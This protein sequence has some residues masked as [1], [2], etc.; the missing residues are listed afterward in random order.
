MSKLP[1]PGLLSRFGQDFPSS[2]LHM[3]HWSWAPSR[4]S[5]TDA[6][7]GQARLVASQTKCA[8]R[9]VT[10]KGFPII[11]NLYA[12]TNCS[13]L[14]AV[15]VLCSSNSIGPDLPDVNYSS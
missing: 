4:L 13:G 11:C 2:K 15:W 8:T 5:D 1:V 14:M 3:K 7:T 10:A 6:L 12:K 9:D